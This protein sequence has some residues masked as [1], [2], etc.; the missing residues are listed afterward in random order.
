MLAALVAGAKERRI[1]LEKDIGIGG[2]SSRYLTETYVEMQ[3][4]EFLCN[5]YFTSAHC[6]DS[7]FA[8]VDWEFIRTSSDDWSREYP[9]YA[10]NYDI[11]VTP[12][13]TGSSS[14]AKELI[15]A[16]A[17]NPRVV[18]IQ[19]GWVPSWSPLGEL[20]GSGRVVNV[21][22]VFSGHADIVGLVEYV[23]SFPDLERIVIT[24]GDDGI[25]AREG[26]AEM[27]RNALPDVE[28]ILPQYGEET[29]ILN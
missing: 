2:K 13:G 5:E 10:W 11:V 12:S 18:F 17:D 6:S 19:V 27:I 4:D 16:Y 15:D 7:P 8:G 21:H 20:A 24:H 28:V 22:S 9:A 25:G 3:A 1:H 29:S 23:K 26:L 14:Y